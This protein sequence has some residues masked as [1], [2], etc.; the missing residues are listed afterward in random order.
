MGDFSNKN[1]L[2]EKKNKVILLFLAVFLFFC[3]VMYCTPLSSDDYE[4]A[5]YDFENLD[6]LSEYVLYYGNGR[7]LGN[8]GAIWLV[9][10]PVLCV[11][12]KAFA[13]TSCVFLLPAVLGVQTTLGYLVSFLLFAGMD[14]VLFGDVFSWT[15]GFNNYLPPIWLTLIIVYVIQRFSGQGS[16]V[17]RILLC[18]A[19]FVL[20]VASQLFVEHSTVIN[21]L[22]ALCF[23]V[24]YLKT[25]QRGPAVA[26][27]IWFIAACVGAAIM[28]LVPVVFFKEGNRSEAYRS[29]NLDSLM[30]L[31]F[32]C[33]KNAIRLANYYFGANG[34][35]VCLGAMAAVSLTKKSR[36]RKVN[37]LLFGI[38]GFSLACMLF[39]MMVSVDGWYGELAILQHIVVVL[40]VALPLLVW[41]RAAWDLA[42]TLRYKVLALLV[43]AVVSLLPLLVVSPTP[44]RVLFQSYVFVAAA[45]L[46]CVSQLE[47]TLGDTVK[48]C[49]HKTIGI[50]SV[51]L[52]LVISLVFFSA[53]NMTRMRDN[54]IRQQMEEGAAEI[55]IY[56]LPYEY[57]S[58]DSHFSFGYHYFYEEMEDIYFY[59]M[60]FD[61]WM[62]DIL[63][64]VK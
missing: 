34:A 49:V 3:W 27:G 51:A 44:M 58:W 30:T 21:V 12:L 11:L 4:F 37:S 9:N 38:S 64:T 35:V 2:S 50:A 61:Q 28:F 40:L 57:F 19:V 59:E 48:S 31:V 46:V 54:Y 52:A 17:K 25:R 16:A 55:A 14:P 26:S 41:M 36:A 63:D 47:E 18:A 45:A 39:G 43:F 29:F 5:M 33:V 56:H 60:D 23:A 62:N 53:L 32:S 10:A 15:S 42:G 22:L 1:R 24:C 7:L 8:A 13:V 20:G 6:V